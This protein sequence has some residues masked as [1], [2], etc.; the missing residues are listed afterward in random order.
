MAQQDAPQQLEQ[1]DQ[2]QINEQLQ[3]LAQ[4]LAQVQA[5]IAQFGAQQQ[6]QNA[7]IEELGKQRDLFTVL[8]ELGRGVIAA[9]A[10]SLA[11]EPTAHKKTA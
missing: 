5:Q 7:R 4:Q 10:D 9:V 3:Q 11:S 6:A 8:F 2:Q 1:P